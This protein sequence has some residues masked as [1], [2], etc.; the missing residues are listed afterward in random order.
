MSTTEE[1]AA[2]EQNSSGEEEDAQEQPQPTQNTTVEGA[3]RLLI[4]SVL[5]A[6]ESPF[7]APEESTGN[8]LNEEGQSI[9]LL[10]GLIRRLVTHNGLP[11]HG[12]SRSGGARL[13]AAASYLNAYLP[14]LNDKSLAA[15]LA[16]IQLETTQWLSDLFRIDNMAG[17]YHID[18][19]EGIVRITRLA[20]HAKFPNFAREGFIALKRLPVIYV[21]GSASAFCQYICLQLGLPLSCCSVVPH[22]TV[23]GSSHTM[24]VAQLER[25]MTEDLADGRIP[26]L[27]IASAGTPVVGHVDNLTRLQKLCEDHHVWLHIRGHGT[28]LRL[29]GA[30]DPSLEAISK[31]QSVTL[32][33]GI[34]FGLPG[35][36]LC[37]L[38]KTADPS[39][40]LASDLRSLPSSLTLQPLSIWMA[41]QYLGRSQLSLMINHATELAKLLASEISKIPEMKCVDVPLHCNHVIIFK[42]SGL[43]ASVESTGILSATTDSSAG[44]APAT[45][46]QNGEVTPTSS[47]TAST[48]ATT[49]EDAEGERQPSAA[50]PSGHIGKLSQTALDN[51]N[52][53]LLR[54]VQRSVPFIAMSIV[55][56]QQHGEC[57]R[58]S[59]LETAAVYGT[60]FEDVHN[61]CGRLVKR[62]ALVNRTI[63]NQPQ[64]LSL[65][66]DHECVQLVNAQET[67]GLATLRFIPRYIGPAAQGQFNTEEITEINRVNSGLAAALAT[68]YGFVRDVQTS[69]GQVF[70]EIGWLLEDINVAAFVEEIIEAGTNL[71]DSSRYLDSMSEVIRHGIEAAQRDLEEAAEKKMQEEGILRHVPI[72]GGMLNWFMPQETAPTAAG[73]SLN[74]QSGTLETTE[75]T[76]K[77]RMQ[78]AGSGAEAG[79]EE[80]GDEVARAHGPIDS[81]TVPVAIPVAAAATAAATTTAEQTDK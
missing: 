66:G 13:A 45:P 69:D 48:A 4:D 55:R 20:L 3:L 57:L 28:A 50:K 47:A 17:Y 14:V 49:D 16:H 80:L 29:A 21:G 26:L 79:E 32:S 31:C 64:F 46:K 23:F 18:H 81:P 44:V 37:T 2:A 70:V 72:V 5:S 53:M 68:T 9:A 41:F 1:Q 7:A 74:L 42:F 52:S 34:W 39:M 78:V 24:D 12:L 56:S 77:Y 6:S 65:A 27:L 38:Y 58:F 8:K 22:N 33:P 19:R 59:P 30:E 63:A 10:L 11:L 60:S 35:A 51:L 71:E 61:F 62:I 15:L 25:Q 76:Y 40:A 36:P 67:S 54:S 73:L 43:A 75:N